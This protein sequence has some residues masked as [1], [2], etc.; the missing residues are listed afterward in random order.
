MTA[1]SKYTTTV[2]GSYSVPRWYET[3]EKQNESV[4]TAGWLLNRPSSSVLAV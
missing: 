2:V 1:Y 4:S 3:L